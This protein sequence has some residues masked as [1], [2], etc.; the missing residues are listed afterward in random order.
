MA[1][2]WG[3]LNIRQQHL[4]EM[5]LANSYVRFL[6]HLLRNGVKQ[7]STCIAHAQMRSRL[8]SMSYLIVVLNLMRM[9]HELW[10]HHIMVGL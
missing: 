8:K 2:L 1:A 7:L 3:Y 5:L 10:A 9:G 4:P 6:T